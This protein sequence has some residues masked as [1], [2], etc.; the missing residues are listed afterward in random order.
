MEKEKM[1]E[2]IEE[3]KQTNQLYLN[4]RDRF[5]DKLKAK[6]SQLHKFAS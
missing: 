5:E 4:E 2:L 1:R 3:L 6:S